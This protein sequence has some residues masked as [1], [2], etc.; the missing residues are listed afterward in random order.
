M[1]GLLNFARI[2]KRGVWGYD[3]T[4]GGG[5]GHCVRLENIAMPL[6]ENKYLGNWLLAYKRRILSS[7]KEYVIYEGASYDLFFLSRRSMGY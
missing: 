1:R 2:F 4:G 7:V 5:G 6:K 3:R